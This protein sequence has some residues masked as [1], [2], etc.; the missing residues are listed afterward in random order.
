M[1][2]GREQHLHP[3]LFFS[4]EDL[5]ALRAR[6]EGQP[7]AAGYR[8]LLD[9]AS[10]L[11][12]D[13]IPG[14]PPLFPADSKG[15]SKHSTPASLRVYYQFYTAGHALQAY[16]QVLAFA[17]ALSSEES[18]AVRARDWALSYAAWQ[19]WS[20]QS[21]AD[22]LP[23]AHCLL[24]SG[25]IYDWLGD[26]LEA[27]ERQLLRRAMVRQLRAFHRG[28]QAASAPLA[29]SASSWVC[30]A[31]AGLGCLALLYE[32]EEASSWVEEV[33]RLF[34]ARV[35]PASFGRQGEFRE[36]TGWWGIYALRQGVLFFDALKRCSGI[37][38]F[39]DPGLQAYPDYLLQS[40]N[41]FDVEKG[42]MER[43][44]AQGYPPSPCHY[45][46][47]LLR[48]A[49]A[50]RAGDLFHLASRSGLQ[51]PGGTPLDWFYYQLHRIP[52]EADRW[53]TVSLSWNA[54]EGTCS[55]SVN[56][57]VWTFPVEGV[58]A[59]VDGVLFTASGIGGGY[60]LRHLGARSGRREAAVVL[61]QAAELRIGG[62]PP[63]ATP[64]TS[65]RTPELHMDFLPAP[66]GTVWFQICK[67]DLLDR[68][69]IRLTCAGRPG[70]G[71]EL[72][73]IDIFP[74]QGADF[75][76]V[77]ADGLTAPPGGWNSGQVWFDGPWEYLWC[78][79]E[80]PARLP[81][82]RHSCHF[83]D[84]GL[85]FLRGDSEDSPELRFRAGPDTG[86]DCGDQNGFSL[87]IAGE[88]LVGGL[89]RAASGD[90]FLSSRQ[91]GL[92]RYFLD[93]F[94][95][96]ALIVDGQP[97][98][99]ER[100][101]E[102]WIG[103]QTETRRGRIES[104]FTSSAFDAVT[105]EAGSVYPGLSGF[106][107]RIAYIK[108]DYF[109]LADAIQAAPGSRVEW[110]LHTVHPLQLDG[111]EAM[112]RGSRCDLELFLLQ[113][114]DGVVEKKETPAVLERERTSYL[115]LQLSADDPR[116]LAVFVPR[117]HS[118]QPRFSPTIVDGRG[119]CGVRLT[120]GGGTVDFVLFR[121]LQQESL[122]VEGLRSDA[123]LVFA[124][125]SGRDA[126]S[127][128][129]LVGGT[130]LKVRTALMQAD[131]PVD[132]FVHQT[133]VRFSARVQA[134]ADLELR[135]VVGGAPKTVRLDG[136]AL[137]ADAYEYSARGRRLS[138][139][140]PA[141]LHEIDVTTK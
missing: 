29:G 55:L 104:F 77:D 4:P 131:H 112:I 120:R 57:R 62:R 97:Q 134:A 28:W 93:T 126:P 3:Y 37:D 140:V 34:Q 139:A 128:Y 82:P 11:V 76:R 54:V 46:Y 20:P 18:Y 63:D 8:L 12:A 31:A 88:A 81:S 60:R 23:A 65:L 127:T 56:Q 10:R 84:A 92:D 95:S 71:L 137:A 40:T 16:G 66:T 61:E 87:F 59:G 98:Q 50:C 121:D 6:S 133:A 111:L 36:G 102:Q 49:T 75:K 117:P 91:R 94:A 30:L 125:R 53:Y 83:A 19:R 27:E 74:V 25:L 116:V 39:L 33:T 68:A 43:S 17:Y 106:R 21:A 7:H 70:P 38:L 103:S 41:A 115:S 26:F 9:T 110:L 135:L 32:E 129:G 72:D 42:P 58:L 114:A 79:P 132:L 90:P 78:D 15:V 113:P 124:R 64:V 35:L 45:R 67:A 86:R 109:V 123:E 48:L 44:W 105:G 100:P 13:P 80:L 24:G 101:A 47:I 5:P 1:T 122:M 14:Q 130:Q 138:L 73:A 51:V 96:N 52:Y 107:R 136:Q 22:D 141:G 99:R 69:T 108:P 85:V 118:A 119:G 2:P 89:P